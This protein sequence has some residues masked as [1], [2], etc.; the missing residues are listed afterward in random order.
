MFIEEGKKRKLDWLQTGSE[1][2]LANIGKAQALADQGLYEEA[3]KAGRMPILVFGEL[4]KKFNKE[5]QKKELLAENQKLIDANPTGPEAQLQQILTKDQIADRLVN[6]TNSMKAAGVRNSGLSLGEAVAI[7]SYTT[8]DYKEING[9][10]NG[11][12]NPAPDAETKRRLDAL[13]KV[14][15]G[16]LDKLKPYTDTATG[17]GE[18]A[19]PGADKQY[20]QGTKFSIKAFWST[21]VGSNFPGVYQITIKPKSKG[22]KVE[23]FSQY[24]HEAEVLF[25]P[26]TEFYVAKRVDVSAERIEVYLEET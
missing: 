20:T 16:A 17:R 1:K 22:K 21:G 12:T 3:D 15:T 4:K 19:W 25:P 7:N 18:T 13:I 5:Y 6:V 11:T 9:M 14:T 26:G 10:L 23:S 24:V 2:F 8:E